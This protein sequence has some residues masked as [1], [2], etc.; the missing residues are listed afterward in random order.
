M[1]AISIIFHNEYASNAS[2]CYP[3]SCDLKT[4]A[5]YVKYVHALYVFTVNFIYRKYTY[6][7]TAFDKDFLK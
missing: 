1:S 2:V 4:L 6:F 5:L 3:V 7:P